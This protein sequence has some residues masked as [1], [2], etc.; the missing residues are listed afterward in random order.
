MCVYVLCLV[1]SSESCFGLEH[2]IGKTQ[3]RM[4]KYCNWL[5]SVESTCKSCR[6]KGPNNYWKKFTYKCTCAVQTHVLQG[7]AV[8]SQFS[9]GW[10]WG[11][12]FPAGCCQGLLSSLRSHPQALAMW[13][14]TTWQFIASKPAGISLSLLLRSL[15]S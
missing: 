9:F 11:P 1:S 6:Y 14:S 13:F 12:W 8:L 10:N 4:Q 7:S 3:L 5:Q 15:S 2:Q